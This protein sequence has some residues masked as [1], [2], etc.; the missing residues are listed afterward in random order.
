MVTA[1]TWGSSKSGWPADSET[2]AGYKVYASYATAN[3]PEQAETLP[4]HSVLKS[5]QKD[6]IRYGHKYSWFVRLLNFGTSWAATVDVERIDTEM[7]YTQVVAFQVKELDIRYQQ[8][9][10]LVADSRYTDQLFWVF[11]DGFR[12]LL[13]WCVLPAMGFCMK[14][15]NRRV[16]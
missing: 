8:K 5:N 2:I 10:V 16:C 4:D 11:F 7:T 3:E 1:M 12:I 13:P 9:K 15:L 14:I 6:L